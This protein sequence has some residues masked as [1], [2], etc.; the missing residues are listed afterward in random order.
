MQQGGF[1]L[2]GAIFLITT[3]AA[4]ALVSVSMVTTRSMST[5]QSILAARA[6]FA[7]RSGIEYAIYQVYPSA[8]GCAEA[9]AGS[10]FVLEGFTVSL[11]CTEDTAVDEAGAMT[12]VYSVT[13]TASRGDLTQST[14]VSRALRVTVSG[15]P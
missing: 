10:P 5:A 2:I 6:Y 15:L 3:V 11:G 7:A 1:G 14:F 13:A 8:Q 9:L 12:A 4:I